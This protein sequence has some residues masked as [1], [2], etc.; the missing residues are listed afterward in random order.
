MIFGNKNLTQ[1]QWPKCDKGVYRGYHTLVE[2]EQHKQYVKIDLPPP[3]YPVQFIEEDMQY[4][5]QPQPA[6]VSPTYVNPPSNRKW[7]VISVVTI[8]AVWG[9][10]LWSVM[11]LL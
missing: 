11:K 8:I 3:I 1:C 6:Q 10:I 5:I 9:M 4:Q 2:W 7:Q